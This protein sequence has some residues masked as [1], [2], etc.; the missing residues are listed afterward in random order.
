[1]KN[2]GKIS[3]SKEMGGDPVVLW[4]IVADT[5]SG[6]T[7][8]TEIL[9]QPVQHG[10]EVGREG[11]MFAWK[12]TNLISGFKVANEDSY[13]AKVEDTLEDTLE[14]K[15]VTSNSFC[16]ELDSKGKMEV[17]GKVLMKFSTAELEV[18]NNVVAEVMGNPSL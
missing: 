15:L 17:V 8:E 16:L 3:I 18:I 10:C 13:T 9:G 5:E 14:G 6:R 4:G 12:R 2:G 7:W 1:M 11:K